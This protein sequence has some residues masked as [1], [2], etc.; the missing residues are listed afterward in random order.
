[1]KLQRVTTGII[2]AFSAPH[3]LLALFGMAVTAIRTIHECASFCGADGVAMLALG[4]A[5]EMRCVLSAWA[6]KETV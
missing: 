1:M 2:M 4:F 6:V 5:L 3:Y